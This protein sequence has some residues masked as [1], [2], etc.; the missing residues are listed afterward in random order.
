M[1]EFLIWYYRHLKS[2]RIPYVL[3]PTAEY[4]FWL[5]FRKELE[6]P[7]SVFES[8]LFDYIMRKVGRRIDELVLLVDIGVDVMGYIPYTKD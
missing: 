4:L 5:D 1:L 7:E 8:L 6:R 3:N 2:K